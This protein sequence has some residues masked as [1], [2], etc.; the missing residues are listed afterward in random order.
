MNFTQGRV[1][2]FLC[3]LQV[4]VCSVSTCK[5]HCMVGTCKSCTRI[6]HLHVIHMSIDNYTQNISINHELT[7]VDRRIIRCIKMVWGGLHSLHIMDRKMIG[8]N[9]PYIGHFGYEVHV[10]FVMLKLIGGLKNDWT[11][12][13]L[14]S[15]CWTI[16][17]MEGVVGGFIYDFVHVNAR[18]GGSF[19]A[20][21]CS[22]EVQ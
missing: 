17:G 22:F 5:I 12:F 3:H 8:H 16:C 1:N 15:S 19:F 10:L 4:H 21:H 14:R 6:N 13:Y 18:Y 9:Y 20:L 11:I 2:V 7:Y